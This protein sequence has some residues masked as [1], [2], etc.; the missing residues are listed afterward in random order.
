MSKLSLLLLASLALTSMAHAQD[1]PYALVIKAP[2]K[3]EP[4]WTIGD[5]QLTIGPDTEIKPSAGRLMAGSCVQLTRDGNTISRVETSA[6]VNC[7]HTDYE[8]FLATYSRL[9]QQ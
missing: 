9:A 1:D 8:A 7:D 5:Q 3:N 4:S 2:D 6:M